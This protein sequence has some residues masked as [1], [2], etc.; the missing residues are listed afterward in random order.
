MSVLP[1]SD[2]FYSFEGLEVS[3]S[4]KT[5]YKNVSNHSLEIEGES[6]SGHVW[7]R[8][9]A[10]AFMSAEQ[11][12]GRGEATQVLIDRGHLVRQLFV[13]T[14]AGGVYLTNASGEVFSITARI[15]ATPKTKLPFVLDLVGTSGFGCIA[16]PALDPL[17]RITSVRVLN[18]GYGYAPGVTA[19]VSSK[20][21]SGATLKP[22]VVNGKVVRIDVVTAGA[23]YSD[24]ADKPLTDY[25]SA[26]LVATR[27]ATL[28]ENAVQLSLPSG[29][30][31][32]G[33]PLVIAWDAPESITWDGTVHPE[34]D[35]VDIASCCSVT[36][37]PVTGA[38]SLTDTQ[39]SPHSPVTVPVSFTPANPLVFAVQPVGEVSKVSV[40]VDSFGR[41]VTT[42]VS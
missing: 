30:I 1:P 35:G 16:V 17:G 14:L 20:T 9:P 27:V 19:L 41:I 12:F 40:T 22:R 13:P 5:F 34:M 24:Y 25:F 42:P 33:I 11:E 39:T 8:L 4:Y 23:G 10:E 7:T 32:A 3:S 18:P 28:P 15:L 6:D 37:D 26:T 2:Y 36:V 29:R 31:P 21:G 38:M